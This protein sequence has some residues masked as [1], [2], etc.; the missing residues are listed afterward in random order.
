MSVIETQ[1][2]EPR[3]EPNPEFGQLA[4][5]EAVKRTAVALRAHGM[6]VLVVNTG[7]EAKQ[8]VL[9]IVPH[10]ASVY[11]TSSQTLDTIGLTHE[12]NETGHYHSI[13]KR[14]IAMD[15]KTEMTEIR[16]LQ[17][18]HDFV[19]GSVHAITE[20]GS[21]LIASRGGSQLP[22]YAYGADRVIW[23]A[24]TQKIVTDIEEGLQRLYQYSLPLED[25]RA[26]KAYG[27][28]SAIN[29]ILIVN[30]ETP[31]RTTVVLVKENLGF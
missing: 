3:K 23:V 14:T 24:G 31:G 30:A 18:S 2:L 16:R 10:G 11:S 1:I 8:A 9:K 6:E 17:S 12:L 13:R 28:S 4:S 19:V 5:D 7:E 29:K 25:V 20:T 27:I 15:R 26:R 22:A 21:V